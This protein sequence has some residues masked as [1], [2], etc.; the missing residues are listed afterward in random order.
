MT[1][2]K[3]T[4]FA[5]KKSR[6]WWYSWY[7]DSGRVQKSLK[8]LGLSQ[9]DYTR[10]EAE[11]IFFQHIGLLPAEQDRGEAGTLA[12]LKTDMLRRLEVENRRKSTIREY[13]IALEH[14]I[15]ALG[16][17]YNVSEVK[18]SDWLIIRQR[19]L[20]DDDSPAT[21]NKIG[22][23]LRGIFARLT[24]DEI[25]AKNP[26]AR[27][28]RIEEPRKNTNYLSKDELR[29]FLAATE[30]SKDIPGK[31]I[32]QILALTGRRLTEVLEIRS[33]EIDLIKGRMLVMN[34]KH[35]A[36]RKQWVPIPPDE[37][38]VHE[39]E[40]YTISVRRNLAWFL[41]Q[42]DSE[43]PLKVYHRDTVSHRIKDWLIES[44]RGDL[45]AH[46]LRHTYITLM[47]ETVELWKLQKLVDHSSITVTERYFHKSADDTEG[48]GLGL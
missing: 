25:I 5:N 17:D 24:D 26:F 31:K 37:H 47:G 29:A 39:E 46:D 16:G 7:T 21:V 18:K 48:K 4:I 2:S 8:P 33:D 43:T 14:M 11:R 22:R 42:S 38:F 1:Q 40:E 28:A 32:A 45:H 41:E 3:P 19:L 35:R 20:N 13:R 27:F 10:E 6:W 36:K 9:A 12:R 44:G 15:A 23:H 34:V 30:R